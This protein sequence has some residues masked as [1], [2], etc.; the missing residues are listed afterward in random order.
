[1]RGLRRDCGNNGCDKQHG[2][3]PEDADGLASLIDGGHC[4]SWAG[5]RLFI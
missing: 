5:V 3:R 4:V 2:P 1:M